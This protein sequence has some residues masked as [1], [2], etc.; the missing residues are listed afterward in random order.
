MDAGFS[1]RVEVGV[2]A[3]SPEAITSRTPSE[4]ISRRRFLALG[5]AAAAVA[6]PGA[7]ARASSISRT[8]RN[9]ADFI[10]AKMVE[11]GVPALS[12]AV[13]KGQRIVWARGF[14]WANVRHGVRCTTDTIFML[15]SVS[16]T[17]VATA[18]MQG[19]EA[20]LFG[21]DDDVNDILPFRVRNPAHPSAVIT[22]RMLLTHTASMRDNWHV[23]TPSYVRGDSTVPLGDWLF[24]YFAARGR[25]FDPD[26]SF[27]PFRPGASYR[28]CNMGVSLAAFLVEAASGVAFDLWCD[29]LIF[30]PLGMDMTGWH[31]ADV[32]RSLVAMPY[33]Y[34][35]F[36][37]AFRPYGQYGY[38]DY[39]DGELRTTPSDLSQHLIAFING[40]HLGTTRILQ[41]STVEE[42]RRIQFPDV[43]PRQGGHRPMIAEGVPRTSCGA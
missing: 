4:G 42:M 43:V 27:Y 18:V 41:P 28:Y 38:P 15:A 37:N 8:S 32:D 2:G 35:A 21:L 36:R 12:A 30:R 16:K 9:L 7:V 5:G 40:G 10:R 34:I 33:K 11:E 29:R 3:L 6:L 26:R 14:G 24:D 39:P 17:V 20:G 22:P 23:L 31:L 13:V 19:V 1:E 25:N